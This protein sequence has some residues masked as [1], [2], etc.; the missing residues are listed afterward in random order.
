M[1]FFTLANFFALAAM[2]VVGSASPTPEPAPAAFLWTDAEFDHWLATTDAKITYHGNTTSNPLARRAA[3]T[4]RVTYCTSRTQDVCGGTCNVYDGGATC[5]NAP[6][7]ACLAATNNVGFCDRAGCGGSCN[8]L[9]SC[10]TPLEAGFCD[11]PGTSS[12]VVSDA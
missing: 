2:A 9:S 4:T 12:I 6:G 8:Q 11:T 1:Q 10:G 7:T 3:L 5:L